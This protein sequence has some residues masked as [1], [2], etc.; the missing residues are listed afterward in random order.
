MAGM[1]ASNSGLCTLHKASLEL[2]ETLIVLRV[3]SSK[4]LP[5]PVLSTQELQEW[6]LDMW[7]SLILTLPSTYNGPNPC[8]Q[9]RSVVGVYPFHSGC[10]VSH[11]LAFK[12]EK[13]FKI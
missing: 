8:N 6:S 11:P 4:S 5:I 1:C 2:I 9:T 12:S 3:K 10:G 7:P 13:L